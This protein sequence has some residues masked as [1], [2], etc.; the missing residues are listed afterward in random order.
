MDLQTNYPPEIF[1][2]LGTS[3]CF[4][5]I[6]IS[7]MDLQTQWSMDLFHIWN[8]W[9]VSHLY[10]FFNRFSNLLITGNCLNI[11]NNGIV[12]YHFESHYESSNSLTNSNC[13]HIWNNLMVW[14]HHC[15]LIYGS[16]NSMTNWAFCHKWKNWIVSSP[17]WTASW[18]FKLM[19]HWTVCHIRNNWMV[20]EMINWSLI[21]VRI[22]FFVTYRTTEWFVT[23]QFFHGFAE[24]L[25][26]ANGFLKRDFFQHYTTYE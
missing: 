13:C 18:I 2:T 9:M 17:L 8:S 24:Q 15:E 14:T 7:F 26:Q 5:T 3:E 16:S 4:L 20:S 10:K 12:F 22:G 19:D 1:A 21:S 6:V 23:T 11:L 25:E